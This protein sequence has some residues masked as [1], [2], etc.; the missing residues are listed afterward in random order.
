MSFARVALE[1]TSKSF[2]RTFEY[3]IPPEMEPTLRPGC[4][5]T[6]PFGKGNRTRVGLVMEIA[7]QAEYGRVKDILVQQDAQPI[8]N[9]EMLSLTKWLR[10]RCFCTYF[11]AIRLMMPTGFRLD[12]DWI[13]SV[14][15][16]FRA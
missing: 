1:N 5:V 12:V 13:W 4:R 3:G 2:D 9:D 6:V 11:D 16:A 10:D 8:L 15:E 14:G 7:P